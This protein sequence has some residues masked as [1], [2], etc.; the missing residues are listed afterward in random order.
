MKDYSLDLRAVNRQ[1]QEGTGLALLLKVCLGWLEQAHRRLLNTVRELARVRG[2]QSGV[3]SSQT[4]LQIKY[5][6][7]MSASKE[8]GAASQRVPRLPFLQ[9]RARGWRGSRARRT[10]TSRLRPRRSSPAYLS[11]PATYCVVYLAQWGAKQRTA[12]VLTHKDSQS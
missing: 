11:N 7:P 10:Q 3:P 9:G 2:L 8:R 6:S 1:C 5:R 12:L 4:N